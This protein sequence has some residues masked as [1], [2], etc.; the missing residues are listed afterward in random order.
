[1]QTGLEGYIAGLSMSMAQ[2]SVATQASMK[3]LDNTLEDSA[4]LATGLVESMT[5]AQPS[6]YGN[7]GGLF[8]SFA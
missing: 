5:A 2:Q 8:D 3:I 7:V 4:A 6:V 1:M